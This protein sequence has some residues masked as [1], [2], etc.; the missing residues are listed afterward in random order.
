M[1]HER[2]KLVHRSAAISVELEPHGGS[3]RLAFDALCGVGHGDLIG[4]T[5]AGRID[6]PNGARSRRF[7]AGGEEDRWLV[8]IAE[9][10]SLGGIRVHKA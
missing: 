10:I 3:R 6:D 2:E 5:H 9:I 7:A 8:E 1:I 4:D